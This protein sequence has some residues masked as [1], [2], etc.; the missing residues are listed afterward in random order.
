MNQHFHTT[1]KLKCLVCEDKEDEM[2]VLHKTR[3]QTHTMCFGCL[4]G[5]INSPIEQMFIC[6][7]AG[8]K[9]NG[10]ILC[11]GSYSGNIRNI[12]KI[13]VK[14]IVSSSIVQELVDET[15][16]NKMRVLSVL[17]E[18]TDQVILCPHKNCTNIIYFSDFGRNKAWCAQCDTSLC[19]SCKSSPYHFGKTCIESDMERGVGLAQLVR[20]EIVKLCPGCKNPTEKDGGCNKMHCNMCGSK[21]CWMCLEINIDYGHYNYSSGTTCSGKLWNGVDINN[22][23]PFEYN[24]QPPLLEHVDG[25]FRIGGYVGNVRFD[26]ILAPLYIHLNMLE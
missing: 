24:D 17:S 6:A 8:N 12:C 19:I 18:S 1:T 10:E 5:Y 16:K 4:V 15:L 22:I 3:R 13:S 21:W 25:E 14:N 20:D 7:K 23:Q 2:F 26:N 11:P 9:V